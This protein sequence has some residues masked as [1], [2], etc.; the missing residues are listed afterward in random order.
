[1]GKP[2]TEEEV[3]MNEELR[4]RFD[5]LDRHLEKQDEHL[6]EMSA[7]FNKHS[8]EDAGWYGKIEVHLDEHKRREAQKDSW[9]LAKYAGW[10]AIVAALAGA[11][12]SNH[13]DSKGHKE[14]LLE[15]K[16]ELK[17]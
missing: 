2:W 13:L 10:F 3:I 4:D 7:S 5:K 8:L 16:A 6:H 11:W 9:R 14:A 17:K 15:I 12:Y 1:M